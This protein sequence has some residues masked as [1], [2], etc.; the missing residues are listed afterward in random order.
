MVLSICIPDPNC[1]HWRHRNGCCPK[2][3]RCCGS[4]GQC[5]LSDP[6]KRT[7]TPTPRFGLN[8]AQ[9]CERVIDAYD[10]VE[11]I[12]AEL[13]EFSDRLTQYAKSEMNAILK[14]KVTA[15]LTLYEPPANSRAFLKLM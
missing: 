14:K 15:I 12:F 6:G 2:L 10:W 5:P 3:P 8:F 13:Q 4:F 7:T 11:Q 9:S 1:R